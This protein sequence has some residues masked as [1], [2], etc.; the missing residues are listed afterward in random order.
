MTSS[1]DRAD[2]VERIGAL[3]AKASDPPDLARYNPGS[4]HYESVRSQ[5]FVGLSAGEIEGLSRDLADYFSIDIDAD[6][7]IRLSPNDGEG[8]NPRYMGQRVIARARAAGAE[9]ALHAFEQLFTVN[10]RHLQGV[11]AVWGLHPVNAFEIWNGI[12]LGPL[13][14]VSP[15]QPRDILLGIPTLA[16]DPYETPGFQVNA[17]PK[18][19]LTWQ[20]TVDPVIS[21]GTFP[22]L[23]SDGS[24][25]EAVDVVRCL[26]LVSSRQVSHIATWYQTDHLADALPA[27]A[28]WG[29][30]LITWAHQFEVEP[31][32]IDE[33]LAKLVVHGFFAMHERDQRRI[34]VVLDRLNAAR[35][36]SASPESRAIDLGIAIEAL[37]FN[38]KDPAGEINYKFKARGSVLA[39]SNPEERR[40][41]AKLLDRIYNL[42]S[43]AAH[44]GSFDE[45]DGSVR[46]TL[47]AGIE[48]AGSLIVRV[49]KIGKIPESWN[50]LILGWERIDV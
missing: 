17:R 20:Y 22:P 10:R 15:T 1:I 12:W 47:V 13:S 23:P 32:E 29:G 28:G 49:I 5:Q 14:L 7:N 8:M 50:G 40:N 39:S 44:G 4:A 41:V 18:A 35:I 38:P 26:T 6:L 48:L 46:A 24:E 21:F 3:A 36:E 27:V 34:R 19:A 45:G 30:Q 25:V 31:E 9:R 16:G 37:L 43:I 42:R 2:L 33:T 11:M